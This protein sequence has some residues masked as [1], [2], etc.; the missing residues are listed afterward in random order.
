MHDQ[1]MRDMLIDYMGRGFLD[2]IIA[3]FRQDATVY[4]FI[5]D[6]VRSEN[7]RV[8]LGAVA[9]VEELAVDRREELRSSVPGL[10][11]LLR[12]ENPTVRGDAA[13]V[14]GIIKDK[15]SEEVLRESLNDSN[16]GVREAAREAL[17]EIGS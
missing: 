14:L 7:M 17:D 8:R 1:E 12:H 13:S 4:R 5:A 11:G 3:L 2:N 6:M 9:L 16:P 10:I 15:A